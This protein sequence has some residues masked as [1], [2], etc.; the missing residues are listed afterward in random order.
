MSEN[1]IAYQIKC[2]IYDMYNKLGSIFFK[3]VYKNALSCKIK[4]TEIRG[5]I[6][7]SY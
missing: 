4:K 6:S 1:E 7:G 2:T 5:K 3:S